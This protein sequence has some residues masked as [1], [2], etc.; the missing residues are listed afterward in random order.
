[1]PFVLKMPKLSPTMEEGRIVKWHKK[2]GDLVKE[3]DLL[4]EV[5]TDKASVEYNVLDG[6]Y[7]RKILT[8]E[9]SDVKINHDVAIFSESADEDISAALAETEKG[10]SQPESAQEKGSEE[11]GAGS[12]VPAATGASMAQP[13]FEPAPPL[14]EY[15]FGFTESGIEKKIS[16]LAKKLAKEKGISI[17]HIE[18][19]GPHGRIMSR[20]LEK[21]TPAGMMPAKVEFPPKEKPGS[22]EVE[23]MSPMRKAIASKLQAAKTFIPHFY[24]EQ[25]IDAEPMAELREQLK[26]TGV[27]VTFND[28]VMRATALAAKMHPVINSGYNSASGEIIRFKTVDVAVAVSIPE[29]LITPIV[30]HSDYKTIFQLSAEVRQ[31]AG[32]AK[33]GKLKPEQYQGGSITIS[34]LGMYGITSFTPIINPPQACILSV[35]GI[36]EE[37]VVKEGAIVAGKRMTC[38]LASDHRVVDGADAAQFLVTLKRYL[39]NPVVL[40]TSL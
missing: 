19:S 32:L 22:F 13:G 7:L 20:D 4:F 12:A 38:V 23:P 37:P 28:F 30:R 9:G 10:S 34:N 5:A 31:L 26:K 15:Q 18:G 17:T 36:R 6:G 33:E 11:S 2:E 1:M 25:E 27:K 14:E 40:I 16:P 35:G 8:P 24:V 21:G 39:E 29:G 3:G